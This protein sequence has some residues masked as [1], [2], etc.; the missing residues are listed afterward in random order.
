[1]SF[2]HLQPKQIGHN[3][4]LGIGLGLVCNGGLCGDISLKINNCHLYLKRLPALA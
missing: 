4:I 2:L 3:R 1:M